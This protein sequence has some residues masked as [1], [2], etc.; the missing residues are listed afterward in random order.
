[1]KRP[2]IVVPRVLPASA[3]DTRLRIAV[4]GSALLHLLGAAAPGPE[5][6]PGAASGRWPSDPMTVRVEPL[7]VPPGSAALEEIV[8]Q[9]S[10][11][12]TSRAARRERKAAPRPAAI[13][14]PRIADPTVYAAAELD[15]L[16]RPVAPLD[17]GRLRE[18]A[19]SPSSDVRLELVIDELGTVSEVA[20]VRTAAST[21]R[22]LERDLRD[23]IAAMPFVPAR[24]D[25]R[26]V[27]SRI[28]LSVAY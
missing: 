6:L 24:K 3:A 8:G 23:A 2:V 22:V 10:A 9:P 26:A 7:P 13:A 16:P 12:A 25:G 28:V 15:S 21:A 4:A 14:A 27:K 1:M 11:P 19:P 20:Y 17:I 18:R 5:A